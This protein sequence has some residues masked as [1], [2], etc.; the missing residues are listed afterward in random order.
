MICTTKY[1]CCSNRVLENVEE[2]KEIYRC[3]DLIKWKEDFSY[4]YN[5]KEY[6]NQSAYN[7]AFEHEFSKLNW[8]LQPLLN[9]DP[10]LIGDFRK[11]DIFIEVQFG[12]SA[13]LYRDYYKFHYGLI[14]DLLSVAVLIVPIKAKDFFPTRKTSVSN[15][16]EFDKAYKYFKLLPIPVPIILIGLMTSN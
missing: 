8:E 1:F 7:K 15:M 5:G 14:H 10:K 12:N 3:I 13:T 4:T 2:I 6:Y 11:N 9:D 16:A